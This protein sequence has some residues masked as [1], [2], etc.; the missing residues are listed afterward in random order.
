MVDD[1]HTINVLSQCEWQLKQ[2]TYNL[3]WVRMKNWKLKKNIPFTLLHFASAPSVRERKTIFNLIFVWKKQQMARQMDGTDGNCFAVSLTF[4]VFTPDWWRHLWN[5]WTISDARRIERICT[6][7]KRPVLSTNCVSWVL[8][9]FISMR[10]KV[11]RVLWGIVCVRVWAAVV[12]E[13]KWSRL[14]GDENG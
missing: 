13:M 7:S 11:L 1:V 3:H 12:F 9:L 8:R 14:N 5:Y 10:S 2:N 4:A 6:Q